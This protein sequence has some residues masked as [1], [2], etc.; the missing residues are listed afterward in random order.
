MKKTLILLIILSGLYSCKQHDKFHVRGEVKDAKGEMLYFEHSEL[1]KTTVIDSVKLSAEGKFSF[2]S[3][4][5]AYPDFYRLRLDNKIITFA[6][7]SCEDI[8]IEAKSDKFATDYTLTGSETSLLIQKLRK[9]VMNIQIKANELTSKLSETEQKEKIAEIEK[10]IEVHKDMARKLILQNPRSA[11][12]YFALYQKVNNTYLF[13][14]YVKE[15][16]PYCAAVATAYNAFMP[17]YD[18]TKN[19]YNLVMDAIKTEREQ[20]NKEAWN[21]VLA[22]ASTGYIDIVLPDKKNVER[23]LS[24]L[25]GKVVLIDFSAYESKES[26]DYTFSLRDL[27][28]KYHNRGFEIYQ[29]SLDQNKLLWQ[30]AVANIPWICVRDENGPN[31]KC[32]ETYNVSSIPTSFLM[33]RKGTIIGRSFGFDELKK[34]IEKNL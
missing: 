30:Q 18:R 4:R 1:M 29:I 23:K 21:E 31:A 16:K 20:K 17:D 8:S 11:A 13:S 28:N 32:A 7:D 34:E 15:D 27:Y 9:S 19:I 12:A 33:N 26:V 5:P 25:Q 3:A 24:A 14:P 10:D 2:K 6:V 22:N